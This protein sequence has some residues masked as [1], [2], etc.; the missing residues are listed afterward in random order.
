MENKIE[1][2]DKPLSIREKLTIH[3]LILLIKVI[4]PFAWNHELTN[5]LD[6]LKA[7]LKDA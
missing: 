5:S 1:Q 7:I 2:Q 3:L 4:K 6:E